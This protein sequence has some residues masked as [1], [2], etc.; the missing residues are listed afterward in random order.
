MLKGPRIPV[1]ELRTAF[2]EGFNLSGK[3]IQEQMEH[4][5]PISERLAWLRVTSALGLTLLEVLEVMVKQHDH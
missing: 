4:E 5:G 3:R 1:R 2:T